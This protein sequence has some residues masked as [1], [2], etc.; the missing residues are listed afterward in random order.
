VF[1]RGSRVVQ[2]ELSPFTPK[3]NIYNISQKTKFGN[4]VLPRNDGHLIKSG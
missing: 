2:I 3:K 4:M 1:C